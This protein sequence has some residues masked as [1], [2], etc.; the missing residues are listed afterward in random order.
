MRY[1]AM[2]FD[3]ITPT[4]LDPEL[5]TAHFDY[6]ALNAD[7]ITMAGGLRP[8]KGGNFCGSL[9]VIEAEN[10]EQAIQL[11]END[12]YCLAGLRPN[13]QIFFWNAAPIPARPTTN[14]KEQKS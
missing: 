9:W 13:R 14:Y 1:T 10:A 4:N 8:P 11:V 6:L 3:T 7:R 2:F 5:T 12:P